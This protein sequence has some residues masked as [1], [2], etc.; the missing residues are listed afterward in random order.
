[1]DC[2][3]CENRKW[4]ELYFTAQERFDKIIMELAVGFI[5]VFVIMLGC[6]IATI[7]MGYKTQKFIDGFEYVEET[8]IQIEQDC[9]GKNTVI[10]GDGSEVISNGAGVYTE[11]EEILEKENNKVNTIH[12]G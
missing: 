7:C 2:K 12:I 11:E 10:L 3:S 5:I 8:E 1:M 4:K 9:R 6:L